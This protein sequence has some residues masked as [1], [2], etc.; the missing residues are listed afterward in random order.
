MAG[1]YEV[2]AQAQQQMGA[3]GMGTFWKWNS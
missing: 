2:V 3:K 1:T